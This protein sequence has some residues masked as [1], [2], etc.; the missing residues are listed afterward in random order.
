MHFDSA[1]A[2]RGP[3]EPSVKDGIKVEPNPNNRGSDHEY[4]LNVG[5][6]KPGF[7]R[8]RRRCQTVQIECKGI[9]QKD[10]IPRKKKYRR[11]LSKFS[12]NHISGFLLIPFLIY[13]NTLQ[14]LY[15]GLAPFW[16]RSTHLFFENTLHSVFLK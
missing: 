2:F 14:K 8:Q 7:P 1:P 10:K 11:L 16:K 13:K 6:P 5:R 3:N 9:Q 4:H 15:D 12:I